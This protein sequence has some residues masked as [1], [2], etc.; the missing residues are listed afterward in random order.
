[1]AENRATRRHSQVAVARTVV[2]E[3]NG[4][5][6]SGGFDA[7]DYGVE[8]L[9]YNFEVSPGRPSY[10]GPELGE[11]KIPEP[12]GR[13]I[14]AFI[15]AI[16]SVTEAARGDDSPLMTREETDVT[17]DGRKV[18]AELASFDPATL[19]RFSDELAEAV[20]AVT[21]AHPSKDETDGLPLRVKLAFFQYVS[22]GFLNPKLARRDATS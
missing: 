20:I 13:Q 8:P 18:A 3:T 5:Q 14:T 17:V 11:V 9:F 19:E 2:P 1:M 22:E 21:D 12:S 7:A 16:Q 4:H 10:T 6:R 15:R